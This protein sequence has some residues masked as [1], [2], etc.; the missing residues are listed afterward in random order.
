MNNV[1]SR[2][3]RAA[4]RA[5]SV[6][7]ERHAQLQWILPLASRAVTD[8]RRPGAGGITALSSI[9]FECQYRLPLRS[10]IDM[11]RERFAGV[12]IQAAW[13]ESR[14]VAISQRTQELDKIGDLAFAQRW[15]HPHLA[16]VR[17]F[18]RIHVFT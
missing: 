4:N 16:V 3:I 1:A 18:G 6:L 11:L 8:L 2:N 7:L 14:L 10:P 5:L 13:S 12:T 15:C 9:S 17:H